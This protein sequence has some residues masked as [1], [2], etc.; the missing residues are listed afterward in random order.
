MC[1]GK[2]YIPSVEAFWLFYAI[3]FAFILQVIYDVYGSSGAEQKFIAGVVMVFVF[4][5]VLFLFAIINDRKAKQE[6]KKSI[7]NPSIGDDM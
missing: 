4:V 6:V 7:D 1:Q 5:F 2:I 3:L